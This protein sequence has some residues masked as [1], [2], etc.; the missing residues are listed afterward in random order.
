[1]YPSRTKLTSAILA[2][3]GLVALI[4]WMAGFFVTSID[5]T[6]RSS[7]PISIDQQHLYTVRQEARATSE[8]VPGTTVARNETV[9]SSRLLARIHRIHVRAGDS[10][11]QGDVLIELEKEDLEARVNQARDQIKSIAAQK[12]DAASKLDRIEE[13]ASRKLAASAEVDAAVAAFDSLSAQLDQAG[14]ALIEAE[15]I[16]GYSEIKAPLSGRI[17]E[18]LAEPGDTIAPAQ[19]LLLLYDPLSIRVEA[20]VRESLA[21]SLSLGQEITARIDAN[22][23]ILAGRID[24]IVPAADRASRSF[25]VKASLSYDP[26]LMTGMFVRLNIPSSATT[27][28]AVPESFITEVG[29]LSLVYRYDDQKIERRYI[30]LGQKIG[31]YVVV[32]AG[33]EPGDVIANPDALR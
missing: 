7:D 11:T 23:Q 27:E 25:M 32:T 18:R 14:Q 19:P 31:D 17:V 10:A 28:I 22:D 1:M 26:G 3:A 4:L 21:L 12:T 9:I 30:R 13:M 20:P 15:V 2:T 16:L 5:P 24:E 29:E 33:L 6:L 8:S